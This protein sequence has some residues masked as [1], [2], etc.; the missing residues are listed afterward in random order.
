MAQYNVATRA[1][2]SS[3]T[4]SGTGNKVLTSLELRAL[5]D[6]ITVSGGASLSSPDVLYLN[7][8]LGNRIYIDSFF[9]YVDSAAS[10]ETVASNLGFYYRNSES[11]SFVQVDTSDNS[12][13]YFASSLPDIFAPIQCRITLSGVDCTLRELVIYNNDYSVAFGEDGALTEYTIDDA[14]TGGNSSIHTI[15]IFNNDPPGSM[16][17]TAFISI[18]YSGNEWDKNLKL[19]SDG[20][21]FYSWDDGPSLDSNQEGESYTWNMGTCS[22]TVVSGTSIRLN[23]TLSGTYTTPIFQF[24]GR[25]G[26]DELHIITASGVEIYPTYKTNIVDQFSPSYVVVEE[27]LVS[28]T[29]ITKT[30]GS[31]DAT[32]EIRSS[33]VDPVDTF[34]VYWAYKSKTN[35]SIVHVMKIDI[36][37]GVITP[38]WSLYTPTGYGVQNIWGTGIDPFTGMMYIASNAPS[39]S[40]NSWNCIIDKDGVVILAVAANVWMR[41]APHY[42]WQSNGRFWIYSD[43]YGGFGLCTYTTHTAVVSID[44]TMDWITSYSAEPFGSGCWVYNSVTAQLQFYD[45]NMTLQ[46]GYSM[47]GGVEIIAASLDGG[48]WVYTV[49]RHWIARY[50]TLGEKITEFGPVTRDGYQLTHMVID[51]LE[52]DGLWLVTPVDVRHVSSSGEIIG[53]QTF[54]PT[55][56]IH[57]TER[58]AVVTNNLTYYMMVLDPDCNILFSRN[59]T[60]YM[61]STPVASPNAMMFS[62]RHYDTLRYNRAVTIPDP[63]D[64]VWGSNG[65]LQWTEVKKTGYVLPKYR[66]HQFRFTLRSPSTNITPTLDGIYMPMSVKIPDIYPQ[67]SKPLYIRADFEGVEDAL[68]TSKLKCWWTK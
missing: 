49:E 4:T 38:T 59:L 10:R 17:V 34:V 47:S 22:G 31:V 32:M 15:P 20:E 9:V 6:G 7:I 1:V 23:V 50:N 51:R 29:S 68:Y 5:V 43:Y 11:D 35:V 36:D 46:H 65:S 19:S 63:V 61:H 55:T 25:Y 57:A 58:G 48:C 67:E 33:N 44:E 62:Y 12:L 37:T 16:P 2:L 41:Y 28:G 56:G 64:P 60:S 26:R 42:D 8:D 3:I 14:P 21:T 54:G 52:S 53:A 40:A 66:Y 18:D 39:Y 30:V 24:N 13:Y 45:G 27:T